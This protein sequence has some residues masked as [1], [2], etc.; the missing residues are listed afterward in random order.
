MIGKQLQ[1]YI[2]MWKNTR[3]RD[4]KRNG[5]P[6]GIGDVALFPLCLQIMVIIRGIMGYKFEMIRDTILLLGFFFIW[7]SQI[8]HPLR[9]DRMYYLC[10]M[11]QA[12]RR[13]YLKNGFVF[14]GCLHSIFVVITSLI[15]YFACRV[16]IFAVVY[17]IADGIM[18]SFLCNVR[19]NKKD[20]IRAVFLKPAMF[21][22][23]YLQFALPSAGL[24]KDDYFFIACSFAFLLLVE[25]PLFISVIRSVGKDIEIIASCEEDLYRC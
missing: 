17:I 3:L 9:L 15:L 25:L 11:D 18:Y 21:L 10:P 7:V 24:E 13:D 14:R 22:S 4:L 12:E 6:W 1:D 23:A 16:N 5:I 20:F 2:L 8:K 19:D